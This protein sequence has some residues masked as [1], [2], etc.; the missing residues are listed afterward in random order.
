MSC[1]LPAP[2]R[3]LL[4]QWTRPPKVQGRAGRSPGEATPLREVVGSSPFEGKE[5]ALFQVQGHEEG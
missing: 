1:L 3:G 4:V 5:E 2:H